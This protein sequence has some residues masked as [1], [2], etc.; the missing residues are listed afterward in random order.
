M[1]V[2]G[3]LPGIND[4]VLSF[5]GNLESCKK[6]VNIK[7]SRHV[8][9]KKGNINHVQCLQNSAARFIIDIPQY[10][11]TKPYLQ[12]LYWLPVQGRIHFRILNYVFKCLKLPDTQILF[13]QIHRSS[14]DTR[15][16]KEYRLNQQVFPNRFG[17]KKPART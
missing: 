14:R 7:L 15:S 12:Q 8:N 2:T 6:F 5:K 9:T 11:S 13:P 10:E 3:Y 16:S 17:E 4:N 1:F